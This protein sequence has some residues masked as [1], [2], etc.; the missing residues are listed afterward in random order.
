MDG[1]CP[2]HV[3]NSSF[4]E[5]TCKSDGSGDDATSITL[6]AASDVRARL[7]PQRLSPPVAI[8]VSSA[9]VSG[10]HGDIAVDGDGEALEVE[11]LQGERIR[12]AARARTVT[13]SG[14]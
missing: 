8:N 1:T 7:A 4:E 10:R 6:L 12:V 13:S 9:I 2:E 3:L 5:T 11:L 14:Q